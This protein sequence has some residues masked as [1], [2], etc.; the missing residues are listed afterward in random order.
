MQKAGTWHEGVRGYIECRVHDFCA[1]YAARGL[2][3]AAAEND[4]RNNNDPATVVVVTED[5]TKTVVV[6]S[7]SSFYGLGRKFPSL[8]PFYGAVCKR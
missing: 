1:K 8:L 2:V 3:A 5:P 4:Q 6:H 7:D